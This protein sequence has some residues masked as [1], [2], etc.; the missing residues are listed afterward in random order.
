[1]LRLKLN[2]AKLVSM[3]DTS[4]DA[5]CIGVV[6]NLRKN[7]V[8]KYNVA[9]LAIVSV[10]PVYIASLL[11]AEGSGMPLWAEEPSSQDQH[12]VLFLRRE[13]VSHSESVE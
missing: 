11:L 4:V 5:G 13:S 9:E 3:H 2:G 12:K 6:G 7:L 1:M 10:S 8:A